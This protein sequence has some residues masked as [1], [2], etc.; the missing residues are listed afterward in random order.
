MQKDERK[1]EIINLTEH[2]E[3]TRD[4]IAKALRIASYGEEW[5]GSTSIC[6]EAVINRATGYFRVCGTSVSAIVAKHR[7]GGHIYQ[8][9]A[10]HGV[11]RILQRY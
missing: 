3:I 4:E 1:M 5:D 6:I 2:K 9:E 8:I 10:A 7:N 11:V